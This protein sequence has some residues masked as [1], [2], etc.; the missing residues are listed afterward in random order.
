MPRGAC[1][2]GMQDHAYTGRKE[3]CV[4]L[5]LPLHHNNINTINNNGIDTQGGDM[6]F[7]P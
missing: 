5:S 6:T 2:N 7:Y 3:T 4:Q 1:L